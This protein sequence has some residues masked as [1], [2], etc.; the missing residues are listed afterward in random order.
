M[1]KFVGKITRGAV[2]NHLIDLGA[3]GTNAPTAVTIA[4]DR[5]ALTTNVGEYVVDGAGGADDDIDGISGF[6]EGMFLLLRAATGRTHT[7]KDENAGAAANTDRIRLPG[8]IDV[9]FTDDECVLL[10]HDD[11]LDRWVLISGPIPA[12]S[13][14]AKGVVELATTAEINTGIDATRAMTPD[15]FAASDYGVRIG[16]PTCI[17]FTTSW[18]VTDGHGRFP[19]PPELNGMN[20][21]DVRV[22]AVTAGTTGTGDVM[23]ARD[24]ATT[25][26]NMLST[27]VTLNSGAR[28]AS[29]GTIDT[30]NDD[31][32]TDDVLRIDVDAIHTTPAKGLIV[33]LGFRIP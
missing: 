28:F 6:K 5:I 19:I 20:L 29:D 32:N 25:I 15:A 18:T 7:L 14:T 3:L 16:I 31:V 24:R 21:V 11:T 23:V 13:L 27:P 30:S 17:D 10:Y 12:A 26:V 9:T 1:P 8:A 4:S 2:F 22:Y 33:T